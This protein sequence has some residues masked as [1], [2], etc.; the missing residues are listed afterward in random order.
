M[1]Y[2]LDVRMRYGQVRQELQAVSGGGQERGKE[3]NGMENK[4]K[5]MRPPRLS[6]PRK[7]GKGW[8][9]RTHIAQPLD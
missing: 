4:K 5:G 6:R 1:V 2:G 9:R 8:M 7:A 3:R